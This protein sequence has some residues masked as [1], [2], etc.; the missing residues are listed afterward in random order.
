MSN[1]TLGSG[2]RVVVVVR[3]SDAS[4]PGT[5][6]LALVIPLVL[7]GMEEPL[8]P[9]HAVTTSEHA[10]VRIAATW[11]DGRLFT[12]VASCGVGVA[13]RVASV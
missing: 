11:A 8:V 6:P 10:T 1:R 12:P 4:G 7:I 9:E 2:G 3:L 13:G 5:A